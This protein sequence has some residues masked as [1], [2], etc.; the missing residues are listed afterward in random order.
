M[1]KYLSILSKMIQ[2]ETISYENDK[3]VTKFLE[4]HQI[5]EEKFPKIHKSL[6]KIN[7]DGSLLF[8]W[9]PA[10]KP[11]N[12]LLLMNHMDTAPIT[13]EWECDGLSGEIKDNYMYGRGTLDTKGP[14]FA[15]L[16]AVEELLEEGFEPNFNIYLA[17]SRNEEIAGDGAIKIREHLIKENV[18]LETVLDEGG[19]ILDKPMPYV[20]RPIAMVGISEKGHIILQIKEINN[21]AESNISLSE[22][23]ELI[24]KHIE[25]QYILKGKVSKDVEQMLRGVGKE[26]PFPIDLVLKKSKKIEPMILKVLPK[27]S[28]E[29][30]SIVKSTI[31]FREDKIVIKLSK[32][33]DVNYILNSLK[34]IFKKY[35]LELEV[36]NQS[37]ASNITDINSK[38]YKIIE[39]TIDSVFENVG[40]S[41]YLM[42]A[43]TDSR[44]FKDVCDCILRFAPL[45]MKIEDLN[46]VH[47]IN[48]R[49]NINTISNM[50]NFYKEYIKLYN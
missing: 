46:R 7:L 40:T 29:A 47:N 13:G 4:F 45:D 39:K 25:S 12:S 44:H 9:Q 8:K 24:K 37:E 3:E 36:L 1:S 41:P 32:H 11:K 17:S 35:D 31:N 2:Q 15:M 18:K 43:G 20:K 42:M 14:L 49:I 22:K 28:E 26:M 23:I 5:L 34:S 10:S 38:G 48:E 6:E 27:V 50:V 19:A 33:D 30:K 21:L 16:M